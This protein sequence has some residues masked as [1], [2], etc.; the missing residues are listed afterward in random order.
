M[1]IAR[2]CVAALAALSI[3]SAAQA[4]NQAWFSAQGVT[5]GASAAPN[6]P[7]G[8][9][10]L[11]CNNTQAPGGRCEWDVTFNLQSDQVLFGWAN[12]LFN[13][14]G[15]AGKFQLKSLTINQ[16]NFPNITVAELNVGDAL[17]L[18]AGALNTSGV[19]AGTYSLMTFR[20][21]KQ[22][23]PGGP[24]QFD[25]LFTGVGPT[26]W[27]S[28]DPSGYPLVAFGP[29]PP[30]EA[31]Y[32][33]VPLTGPMILVHNIPEPA[34]LGLLAIGCVAFLRRRFGR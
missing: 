29:N 27:G 22:K 20:L 25:P 28:S 3:T 30:V 33:G 32:T 8:T 31:F 9:L 13:L 15:H 19:P 26:E 23:Q 34:T 11:E 24:E 17:I 5:A 14:P 1:K 16:Q 12:E 18:N 2:M 10:Q 21:S 6:G 4:V 7:G